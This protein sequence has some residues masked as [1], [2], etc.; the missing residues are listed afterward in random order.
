MDN[1]F[2]FQ[3]TVKYNK[4]IIYKNM[5]NNIPNFSQMKDA[6]LER[7]PNFQTYFGYYFP[8]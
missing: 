1:L 2:Q 4:K 8:S 5:E 3:E 6:H 7:W